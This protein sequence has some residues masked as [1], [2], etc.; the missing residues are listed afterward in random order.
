M[1]GDGKPPDS[2]PAAKPGLGAELAKLGV[3]KSRPLGFTLGEAVKTLLGTS[4]L[5]AT[6]NIGEAMKALGEN[7]FDLGSAISPETFDKIGQAAR[8][9]NRFLSDD[10]LDAIR[11]PQVDYSDLIAIE[12]GPSAEEELLSAI[13]KDMAALRRYTRAQGKNVELQAQLAGAQS[14]KLDELIG[15]IHEATAT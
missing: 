2:D 14:G 13:R 8:E 15:A 6:P 7:P 12:P 10:V 4:G 5:G 3:D 1:K 9:N 11:A